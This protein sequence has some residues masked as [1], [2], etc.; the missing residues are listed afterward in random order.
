MD[1]RHRLELGGA[2]ELVEQ[3]AALALL[4]LRLVLELEAAVG[5]DVGAS[6]AARR[7]VLDSWAAAW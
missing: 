2:R 5:E 1:V 7:F 3:V 6:D 4:L